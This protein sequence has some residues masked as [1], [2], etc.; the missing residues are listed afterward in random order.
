MKPIGLQQLVKDVGDGM[1]LEHQYLP[2]LCILHFGFVAKGRGV[3]NT[4]L[5]IAKI[6]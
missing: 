6:Y 2:C 3:K 1:D 5:K 4:H